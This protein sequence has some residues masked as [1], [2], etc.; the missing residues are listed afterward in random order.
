VVDE[1]LDGVLLLG[2]L[3]LLEQ[4][5]AAAMVIPPATA[6]HSIVLLRL[7]IHLLLCRGSC[8]LGRRG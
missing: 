3:E 6:A 7:L 5:L 8:Q 4:A 2:L 1:L